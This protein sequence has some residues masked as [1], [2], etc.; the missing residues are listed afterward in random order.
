MIS[1]VN[2]H[3]ELRTSLIRINQFWVEPQTLNLKL[4]IK[5]NSNS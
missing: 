4:W 5:I 1:K 2:Y 3:G